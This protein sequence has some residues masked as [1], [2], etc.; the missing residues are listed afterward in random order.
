LPGIFTI[1]FFPFDLV[2]NVFKLTKA[3]ALGDKEALLEAKTRLATLPVNVLGSACSVL[4]TL[5][6]CSLVFKTMNMNFIT[7]SLKSSAIMILNTAGLILSFVECVVEMI[8][9]KRQVSF[10]R[11]LNI[12]NLPDLEKFLHEKDPK[13][14]KI[15]LDEAL[16]NILQTPNLPLS[17]PLQNTLRELKGAFSCIEEVNEATLR[18]LPSM[19]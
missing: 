7:M 15:A 19:R 8:A 1:L 10:L 12:K 3:I 5:Y 6:Q 13:I 4:T 11:H 9:I 14:K 18:A 16:D 2:Y 17:S